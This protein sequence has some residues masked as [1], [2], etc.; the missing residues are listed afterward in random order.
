VSKAV[1][2]TGQK[3]GRLTA[4][5][6]VGKD[7][8]RRL[9][10]QCSCE[11]GNT[12]R[13]RGS[14]LRRGSTKSCGCLNLEVCAER[15]RKNGATNSRKSTYKRTTHGHCIGKIMS[16]EYNSYSSMVHRC[17]SSNEKYY[18]YYGSRGITVCER[19]LNSFENFLEDMGPRPP[20][21][22]IDRINNDGNYEPSN[23]RWATRKEQANNTRIQTD[24]T[25]QKFGRLTA[26]KVVGNDNNRRLI[27]QCSCECG[28]T[29][30]VLGYSLRNGG[31]KSCGCLRAERH[32]A[33][34]K[35][36]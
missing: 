12:A 28:N 19:W 1:D 13:V 4:E 17:K 23:C 27:W 10:W 29:S 2:I 7:N 8:N 33:V 18:K 21:T 24:I 22:S 34:G 31:T 32:K 11:C 15:G 35:Q 25:G 3:F 14:S 30:K 6:V 5:K 20:N 36:I 16:P 9:I 26:E